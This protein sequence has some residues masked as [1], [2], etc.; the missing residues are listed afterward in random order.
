MPHPVS[1]HHPRMSMMSRAAQFSAFEAL[2]G[3]SERI[4]E[5]ENENLMQQGDM[6]LSIELN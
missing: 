3:H 6:Y 4:D 1:N 5:A 2:S